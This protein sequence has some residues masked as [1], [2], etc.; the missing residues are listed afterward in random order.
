M[1]TNHTSIIVSSFD[2]SDF[3]GLSGIKWKVL[4]EG[5]CHFGAMD[6]HQIVVNLCL[7]LCLDLS[8]N[9]S[10]SYLSASV[11]QIM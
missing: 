6:I 8:T 11:V 3:L 9:L 4:H 7:N 2:S 10:N 1:S 5:S